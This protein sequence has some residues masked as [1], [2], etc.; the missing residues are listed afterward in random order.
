VPLGAFGLV[1]GL[2]GF[3]AALID[4]RTSL[5]WSVAGL[6]VCALA[7]GVNLAI[8]NA[9]ESPVSGRNAP[10]PWQPVPDR[11]FVAPPAPQP[12]GWQEGDNR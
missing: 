5:R 7:L 6:A 1:F 11:P 12:D 4:P 9:P 10:A 8:N 2:L 3:I